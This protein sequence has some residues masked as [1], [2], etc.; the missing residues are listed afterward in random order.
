MT[1]ELFDQDKDTVDA[2][3]ARAADYARRLEAAQRPANWVPAPW[4]GQ[5]ELEWWRL[6]ASKLSPDSAMPPVGSPLLGNRYRVSL[7]V[8]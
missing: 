6:F 8:R 5:A 1:A 7:D 4:D 2:A 3:F